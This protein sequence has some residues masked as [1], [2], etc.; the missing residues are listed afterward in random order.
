MLRQ[1]PITSVPWS[2]ARFAPPTDGIRIVLISDCAVMR[3]IGLPHPHL[4]RPLDA[5]VDA[6]LASQE[7]TQA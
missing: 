6:A 2:I 3:V 1:G 7:A 5:A 4:R